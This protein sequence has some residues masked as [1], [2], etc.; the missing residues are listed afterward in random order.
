MKAVQTLPGGFRVIDRVSLEKNRRAALKVNLLSA[1]L[2]LALGVPAHLK[3]SCLELFRREGGVHPLLR[4]AVMLLAALAYIV[5]HELTHAAVM[6]LA[7]GGKVRF[8]FVK[9]MAYAG[10]EGDW[11]D[12]PAYIAV[13]LAPVLVWGLVFGLAAARVSREWFWAVWFL[14]LVNVSGAAGDLYVTA[15]FLRLPANILVRDTG[16]EMTVYSDHDK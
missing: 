8:G 11:F 2:F 7:G 15:R 5:L 4:M 13:A 14:Q 3:V 12:K 10:S 1:A 16:V 6:K 9:G